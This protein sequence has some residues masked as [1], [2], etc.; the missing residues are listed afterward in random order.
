MMH[1]ISEASE[2]SLHTMTAYVRALFTDRD[3]IGRQHRPQCQGLSTLET[4]TLHA[5]VLVHAVQYTRLA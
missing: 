5:F 3:E 4:S 1:V 2:P